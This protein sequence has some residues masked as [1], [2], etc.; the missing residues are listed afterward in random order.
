M[1]YLNISRGNVDADKLRVLNFYSGT[2]A[3]AFLKLGID[4][5]KGW[6]ILR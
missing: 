6:Q 4:T 2:L 3:S 1:Q 5:I